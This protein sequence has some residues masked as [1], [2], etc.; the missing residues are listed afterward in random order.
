MAAPGVSNTLIRVEVA[1]PEMPSGT[2]SET[3]FMPR[4]IPPHKGTLMRHPDL[5]PLEMGRQI[6][7]ARD[8]DKTMWKIL[9]HRY[10]YGKARLIQLYRLAKQNDD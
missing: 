8:I 6:V 1:G 7:R 3:W 5:S 2:N 4:H 9:C 10:G